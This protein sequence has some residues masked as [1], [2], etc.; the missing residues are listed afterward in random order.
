MS[1]VK[2]TGKA[3]EPKAKEPK[4]KE[5][6]AKEPKAK[7]LKEPKTKE[8]SIVLIKQSVQGNVFYIESATGRVFTF[9]PTK[10]T[11]IGALVWLK[12]DEKHLISKTNGCLSQARVEYRTDV[13]EVMERLRSE[14]TA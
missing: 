14:A 3:K 11:H 12:D 5:P 2:S 10:P 7:E 9:H 4:A 8:P 13:K 1:T 6:K